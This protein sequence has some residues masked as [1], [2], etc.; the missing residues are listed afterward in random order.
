MLKRDNDDG[1]ALGRA[2]GRARAAPRRARRPSRSALN[3]MGARSVMAGE[4]ERGVGLL[5][6]SLE[7]AREHELEHRDRQRALDARLGLGEMYELERAERDAARS[8]RVRRGARSRLRVHARLARRGARL[9]RALGRR[10]AR[11]PR[12][13]ADADGA[14]SR[15]HRPDRA[16]ARAR[17][18]RRP[19][20]A[21][22][23]S[24]RRSRWPGRAA[25][26]SGSVTCTPRAR[27]RPGSPATR[28]DARR[29]PRRLPA[30]AR[31]APSLVRR[32]AR[33]LAVEGRRARRGA[34]LDRRAVSPAD[35]RASARGRRRAWRARGCPYEAARALA[36]SEDAGDVARRRWRS[37]TGSARAGG[38]LARE[39]LRRSAPP[40]RAGRGRRRAP[41][42]PS[43]TPRELEVLRLVAEGLRN[44]E[45]AER[46]VLSPRTVDHHVSA[47]LRKLNA[48]TRGEAAAR[49]PARP[50]RRPVAAARK[51]GN[52]ADVRRRRTAP[53]VRS[54]STKGSP[55]ADVRDPAPRRLAQ[56]RGPAGGRGPL[57][58]RGRPDGRRHP[59]D[60]QLRDRGDRRLGRH[61]VHLPGD[62]PRGDPRARRRADLPVD[63]I[64]EVADT[65]IVRP[66]P[67]PAI[68]G[69]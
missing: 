24:T 60:P 49:R 7:V 42:P 20:R 31:E 14:I 56:R 36:E 4:I 32:R 64:V 59:L 13:L 48:R 68:A 35:R 18:A 55:H 33:L 39:R 29:G 1:V 17:A 16:R 28:A 52:P 63:E 67:E 8:H 26:S 61:G 5:E 11:S 22:A 25:T 10:R 6:Q 27:R 23:R 37:S 54:S 12:V 62:Q 47:V 44:A 69:S 40:C 66:D 50:A 34:G 15:D 21:R 45:I 2:G 43:L 19:G 65:V 53:S 30:R 9:P 51:M 57:D 46:L 58:R 3:M 38:R 41:I